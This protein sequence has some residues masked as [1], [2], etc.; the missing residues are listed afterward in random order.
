[1]LEGFIFIYFLSALVPDIATSYFK[2]LFPDVL[3]GK[4]YFAR[5][6]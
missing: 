6:N 2:L 1:M 4:C 3:G 5:L